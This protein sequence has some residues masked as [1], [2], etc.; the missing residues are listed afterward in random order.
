MLVALD[1]FPMS[2]WYVG[3]VVEMAKI[4]QLEY[5]GN[6]KNKTRKKIKIKSIIC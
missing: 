4:E 6:E 3:H 5:C 2:Q 1:S